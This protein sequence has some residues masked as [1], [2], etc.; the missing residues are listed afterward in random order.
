MHL[1]A[2]YESSE[3]LKKDTCKCDSIDGF[4]YKLIPI[5]SLICQNGKNYCFCEKCDR[6]SNLI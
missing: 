4:Y 2:R 6:S 5:L 1:K 3:A